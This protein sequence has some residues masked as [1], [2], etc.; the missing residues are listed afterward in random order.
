MYF[1]IDDALINVQTANSIATDAPLYQTCKLCVATITKTIPLLFSLEDMVYVFQQL[2]FHSHF[3]EVL[4]HR[5]SSE[6]RGIIV[7]SL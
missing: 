5:V 2:S 6:R 3:H 4:A 1:S 7:G